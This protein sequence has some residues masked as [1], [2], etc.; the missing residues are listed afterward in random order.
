MKKIRIQLD[1]SIF[2]IMTCEV[3]VSPWISSKHRVSES[4][5]GSLPWGGW[6]SKTD[7]LSWP[8][9]VEPSPGPVLLAFPESAD[10]RPQRSLELP[11][12]ASVP[13]ISASLGSPT[14]QEWS[15]HSQVQLSEPLCVCACDTSKATEPVPDRAET[16]TLCGRKW[17]ARA[18]YVIC[19]SAKTGAFTESCPW[20]WPRG[21][22]GPTVC[23]ETWG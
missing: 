4:L 15:P 3:V 21:I 8:R 10:L 16:W 18:T 1:Y 2:S 20:Q 23:S 14:G 22:T 19:T 17:R 9:Q 11:P 13:C 7:R 12:P 6:S 5:H